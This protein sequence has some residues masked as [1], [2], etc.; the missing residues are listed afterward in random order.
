[1][2]RHSIECL[3]ITLLC[4]KPCLFCF[5]CFQDCQIKLSFFPCYFSFTHRKLCFAHR[6]VTG[7]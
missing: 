5:L 2:R 7:V 3:L 1:M 4:V 6:I